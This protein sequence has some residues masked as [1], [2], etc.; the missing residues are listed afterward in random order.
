MVALIAVVS[1]PTARSHHECDEWEYDPIEGIWVCISP[2]PHAT[3]TPTP[4]PRPTNTPTPT[5]RP[6]DTPRPAPTDTPKPAPTDT[7]KPAPTDTPRPAP[8]DTPR[9]APTD[10]PKPSTPSGGLSAAK[11]VID[12]DETI[13]VSAVNVSPSGQQVYIQTSG[14]LGFAKHGS[15]YMGINPGAS[16]A[17]RSW[18]LIGCSPPGNGSVTLKTLHNGKTLSLAT[19]TMDVQA[20]ATATPTPTAPTEEPTTG[21]TAVPPTPSATPPAV[22]GLTAEGK[23]T[24]VTLGWTHSAGIKRY[25]ISYSGTNSASASSS[26]LIE[27]SE[28][29]ATIPVGCGVTRQF[30]IRASGDGITYQEAWGPWSSSVSATTKACTPTPTPG[31]P[32]DPPTSTPTPSPTP[33]PTPTPVPAS[34]KITRVIPGTEGAYVRLQWNPSPPANLSKLRLEWKKDVARCKGFFDNIPGCRHSTEIDTSDSE[35][36]TLTADGGFLVDGVFKPGSGY[37]VFKVKASGTIERPNASDI[38]FTDIEGR[39]YNSKGENQPI[40]TYPAPKLKVAKLLGEEETDLELKDVEWEIFAYVTVNLEVPKTL[41]DAPNSSDYLVSMEAPPGTGLQVKS[42]EAANCWYDPKSSTPWAWK[43]P[44]S[45]R[46]DSLTSGAEFYLVRCSLGSGASDL[47]VKGRV[48]WGQDNIYPVGTLAKVEDVKQAYHQKDNSITYRVRGTN[49]DTIRG[50]TQGRTEGMFPSKDG[51]QP[52]PLLLLPTL[53]ENAAAAWTQVGANVTISK[54]AKSPEVTIEGYWSTGD[55]GGKCKGIACIKTFGLI[56]SYPHER[57]RQ[58]IWLEEPPH[59]PGDKNPIEWSDDVQ[60]WIRGNRCCHY[61]PGTLA[62]EL[63]HTLGLVNGRDTFSVMSGK[64][65]SC[66]P[67]NLYCLSDNDKNGLKATY[68]SH[69]AH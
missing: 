60:K 35:I 58:H 61:L 16:V 36:V 21:P 9:P 5:P 54:S 12:V 40:T 46:W 27:G 26:R 63:G 64:K 11:S 4:T 3:A 24:D 13:T 57:Q 65:K 48:V 43:S 68:K 2:R 25:E 45:S 53:Y 59:W 49:G 18:K 52:N 6:T 50:V 10:T 17:A 56:S 37:T 8:T 22:S 23:A 32:P 33:V 41:L 29:S 66:S 51:R 62:H 55:V 69:D 38:T 20:A 30:E 15:C 28:S 39:Y 42:S 7:P 44:T 1:A 31:D 19:I 14:P 34:V 47:R 67:N